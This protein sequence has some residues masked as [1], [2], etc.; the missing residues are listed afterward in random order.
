MIDPYVYKVTDVVR[1]V[2]GDTIDARL[3]LGFGI[4][5]A[6]R[7]RLLG[8]DTPESFG[9]A[10]EPAGKVAAAFTSAWLEERKGRLFARTYKGSQTAVGLGDGAFGRWLA[11]IFTGDGEHLTDALIARR[12]ST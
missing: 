8:V 7:F 1:V 2:D 6:F 12:M 4:T 10:A 5:A 11:D 3:G 9:R